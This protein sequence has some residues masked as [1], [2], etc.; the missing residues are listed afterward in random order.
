MSLVAFGLSP[1]VLL[2]QDAAANPLAQYA[3]FL[4]IVMIGILFFFM[5]LRPQQAEQKKRDALLKEIKK[6]DRVLT[7]GG[8]FG[9]VTNVQTDVNEVTIRVDEK[10]DTKLRLQLSA[11]ARVLVDGENGDSKTEVK[12]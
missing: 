10:N 12:N 1:L 7:T 9:V 3:Q 6:N 8:I 5:I 4:P 2:A 11:I